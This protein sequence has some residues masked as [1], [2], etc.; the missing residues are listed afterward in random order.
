MKNWV[1]EVP[2]P[3]LLDVNV[4]IALVDPAHVHHDRA[5]AWFAKQGRRA[6]ATCPI[7]ENGLIRILGHP[8]YPNGPASPSAALDRL[9]TLTALSGHVFWPDDLSLAR[10]STLR[11]ERLLSSSQVTDT[12][13]LALAHAKGG[14]LATFDRKLVTSAVTGGAEALLLLA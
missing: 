10:H 5:H 1:A 6:W 11:A 14:L 7:T 13:L 9:K 2:G 4:L 8:G 3:A 12:Y